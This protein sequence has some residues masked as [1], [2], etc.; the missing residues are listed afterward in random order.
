MHEAAAAG[1]L[2]YTDNRS[3]GASAPGE[4]G[5][6]DMAWLDEIPRE[7]IDWGPTIDE[8][9]C[10]DGCRVCLD[11]CQNGVYDWVDSRVRVMQR[12]A[13]VVGCSHCATLCEAQAITFPSI[14]DLRKAHPRS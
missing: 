5:E 6:Q 8:T 2:A 4:D 9:A 1:P 7:Q 13:C 3:L 11:F 14:E 12:T 10:R